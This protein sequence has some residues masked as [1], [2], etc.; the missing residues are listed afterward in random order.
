MICGRAR[1]CSADRNFKHH[2]APSGTLLPAR[3]I[4]SR[5]TIH[6]S[7]AV[8]P[9]MCPSQRPISLDLHPG[10]RAEP[11]PPSALAKTGAN[12][13]IK[14]PEKHRR[15][16]PACVVAAGPTNPSALECARHAAGSSI[17][18]MIFR[19]A[20]R[21]AG[22]VRYRY[23]TLASTTAPNSC[24]TDGQRTCSHSP[25][26]L[27]GCCRLAQESG[28]LQ[29]A[30]WREAPAPHESRSGERRGRGTR[31]ASRCMNSNGEMT[32]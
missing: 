16:A 11:S 31:A 24:V 25:V 4:V 26:C 21:L 6:P 15:A 27:P 23:R 1:S 32:R 29:P 3:R 19:L 2:F 8:F 20:P 30:V 5:V 12:S 13:R 18:A 17:A 9:G 22:S 28:Q 10:T 7:P 14:P